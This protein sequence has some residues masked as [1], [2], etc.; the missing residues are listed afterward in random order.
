M[1]TEKPQSLTT[2]D[3]ANLSDPEMAEHARNIG[4]AVH[5][6]LV[7][8]GTAEGDS[9]HLRLWMNESNGGPREFKEVGD[10]VFGAADESF[11]YNTGGKNTT[12]ALYLMDSDEA[13]R[14]HGLDT[15]AGGNTRDP[16]GWPGGIFRRVMLKIVGT[17]YAVE[18]AAAFSG[19]QG[20]YDKVI[21]GA[22]ADAYVAAW[23]LR[24]KA[25]HGV[26]D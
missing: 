11:A 6:Q 18:V 4:V 1:T 12:V 15:V 13:V 9:G 24:M 17:S 5:A 14:M 19:I 23:T 22:A 8:D 16:R 20:E 21:A 2:I 10:W 26:V 7:E 3:F 25:M